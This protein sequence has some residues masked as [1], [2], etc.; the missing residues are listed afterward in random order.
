MAA[1]GSRVLRTSSPWRCHRRAR[2]L[3]AR[4]LIGW[5]RQRGRARAPASRP[6]RSP[7]AGDRPAR[8]A[9]SAPPRPADPPT[10]ACSSSAAAS[11]TSPRS[12]ISSAASRRRSARS[13]GSL[14]RS[15]SSAEVCD[16]GFARAR[17]S[18][19]ACSIFSSSGTCSSPGSAVRLDRFAERQQRLRLVVRARGTDRRAAR[20]SAPAPCDRSRPRRCGAGRWRPSASRRARAPARP[21]RAGWGGDRPRSVS[22]DS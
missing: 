5:R 20:R 9:R 10:S 12:A 19:A 6:G 4:R 21:A 1:T 15:T 8:T 14:T 2:R 13:L 22:A 17:R 18:A 7:R 3:R 16:G 11:R